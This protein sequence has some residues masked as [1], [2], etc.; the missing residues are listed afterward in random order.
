MSVAPHN[1]ASFIYSVSFKSTSNKTKSIWL[2]LVHVTVE[3]HTFSP[4][5]SDS[6]FHSHVARQE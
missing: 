1:D 6:E 2:K 3:A 4:V 5:V